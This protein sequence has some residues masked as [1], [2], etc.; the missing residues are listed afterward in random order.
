MNEMQVKFMREAIQV[1]IQNVGSGIGGP[2]GALVVLDNEQLISDSLSGVHMYSGDWRR[3]ML[4]CRLFWLI[5][6]IAS[7]C[8]SLSIVGGL[9]SGRVAVAHFNLSLVIILFF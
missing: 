4:M 9:F 8:S 3:C 2:F 6:L 7:T 5:L 1:S